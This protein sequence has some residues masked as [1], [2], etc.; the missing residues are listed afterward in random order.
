MPRTQRL[1]CRFV[2]AVP[3]RVED[4]VL[5]V[6]REYGT[7][8]HKCCCG[9]GQEVV[10]PIGP[11][12]WRIT[13]GRNGVS[14]YPSIGN[15]SFPCRS[16]YWIRHGQILWAEQMTQAQIDADRR[17]NRAAKQRHYGELPPT[18]KPGFWARL[19]QILTGR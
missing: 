15:W 1:R 10:T 12:D 18:P 3:A 8:V 13:T 19:W 16:H 17:Y 4:G 14:L 6:S 11:T 2:G 7:A 9:C 5:Y